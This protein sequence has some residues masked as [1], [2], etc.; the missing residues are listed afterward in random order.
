MY[1][2]C[3]PKSPFLKCLSALGRFVRKREFR[4]RRNVCLHM[5]LVGRY[6][7]IISTRFGVAQYE[8]PTSESPSELRRLLLVL[9]SQF[10]ARPIGTAKKVAEPLTPSDGNRPRRR[11]VPDQRSPTILC[12]LSESRMERD[13]EALLHALR[14][15]TFGQMV[16]SIA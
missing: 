8:V 14:S 6:R 4:L 5:P 15:R 11:A 7:Q 12:D 3:R 10:V 1:F 13:R 16:E 9:V 2:R